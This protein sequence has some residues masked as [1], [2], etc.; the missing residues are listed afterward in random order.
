MM[1]NINISVQELENG[2]CIAS[3]KEQGNIFNYEHTSSTEAIAKVVQMYN[4]ASIRKDEEIKTQTLQQEWRRWKEAL[5]M[6]INNCPEIAK[7]MHVADEKLTL[8]YQ[9]MIQA[10]SDTSGSAILLYMQA[11][12]TKAALNLRDKKNCLKL[13]ESEERLAA[14][15]VKVRGP[16]AKFHIAFS[17]DA[18]LTISYNGGYDRLD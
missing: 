12:K 15:I 17:T 7:L 5:T 3:I 10:Q 9:N 6:Y 14:A 2:I 4:Q 1:L 18:G 8:Y 13:A 16:S 11:K